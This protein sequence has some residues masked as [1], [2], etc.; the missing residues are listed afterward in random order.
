MSTAM[1]NPIIPG[2]HPDPSICRVG[3][4]YY[5]ATSSFEYW[6]GV[7]LFHS[8]DL[9]NWEQ[10]GHALHRESQFNLAGVESSQGIWAP[11]LRYYQEKFWMT[12]TCVGGGGH[13][14]VH[15]EGSDIRGPWSDAVYVDTGTFG[16]DPDLYWDEAGACWFSWMDFDRRGIWQCKIDE[17]TGQKLSDDK[18]IWTGWDCEYPE[19]SHLYRIG[20]QLYIVVAEGGTY[21]GHM[22]SIG[23]GENPDGPF[24]MCPKN[25][26]LTHRH[27]A[28]SPIQ[29]A[30]HGD[31]VQTPEGDWWI[32]FLATRS[33]IHLGRETFIAPVHW[34]EQGWPVVNQGEAITENLKAMPDSESRASARPSRITGF[35][36]DAL[37][38]TWSTRRMP[39]PEAWSYDSSADELTIHST[40]HSLNDVNHTSWVGRRQ[41]DMHCDFEVTVALDDLAS[42]SEAGLT[43][44]QNEEHHYDLIVQPKSSKADVKYEIFARK[45]IGDLVVESDAISLAGETVTLSIHADEA[46]YR[47]GIEQ[48]GKFDEIATGRTKLLAADRCGSFTGVFLAMFVSGGSPGQNSQAKFQSFECRNRSYGG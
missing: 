6:P 13:L 40:G 4:D 10:V 41:I 19:G 23:R 45:Q 36:K 37:D 31:L 9:V 14:I 16:F 12:T 48:V 5:L 24:E 25:P 43:I 21:R 29:H 30:G 3:S 26:I 7:P 28:M 38:M 18:L 1:P 39:N 44:W 33:P 8:R 34:D 27:R 42:G 22:V 20:D 32:V 46:I 11:T 35:G 17:T 15:T 2:F 47:L